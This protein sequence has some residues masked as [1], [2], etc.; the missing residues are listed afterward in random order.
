M[1]RIAI[2]CC[3]DLDVPNI[4]HVIEEPN[5]ETVITR[6]WPCLAATVACYDNHERQPWYGTTVRVAYPEERSQELREEER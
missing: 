5:R 4:T 2:A 6:R 3:I 1:R